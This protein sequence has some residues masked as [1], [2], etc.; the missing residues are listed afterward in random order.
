MEECGIDFH[1]EVGGDPNEIRC[2]EGYGVNPKGLRVGPAAAWM[3]RELGWEGVAVTTDWV[4]AAD[5]AEGGG[6]D[7]SSFWLHLGRA[8][9]TSW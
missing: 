8:G 6:L 7:T 3:T 9:Y 1:H 4:M 5:L 2:E